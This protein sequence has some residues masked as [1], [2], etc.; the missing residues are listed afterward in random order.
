MIALVDCIP[1]VTKVAR[2]VFKYRCPLEVEDLVQVG[3]MALLDLLP[4]YSPEVGELGAFIHT[5][6]YAA[7]ID[8]IRLADT[9]TRGVRAWSREIYDAETRLQIQLSRRPTEG[10]VARELSI[11]TAQLGQRRT[12]AISGEVAMDASELSA[13]P[14]A[15]PGMTPEQACSEKQVAAILDDAIASLPS[16]AQ[17]IVREYFMNEKGLDAIGAGLGITAGR[18]SQI[19]SAACVFIREYVEARM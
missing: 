14:I 7:M 16:R 11:T 13:L 15:D 3:L 5:R 2:Q 6:A 12:R 9:Q 1:Q 4:E 18:A 19:K 8:A 17:H 10:E